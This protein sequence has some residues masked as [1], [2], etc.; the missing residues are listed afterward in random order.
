MFQSLF[1]ELPKKQVPLEGIDP[2]TDIVAGHS[3]ISASPVT[4]R[5]GRLVSD[6]PALAKVSSALYFPPTFFILFTVLDP[7]FRT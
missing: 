6:E 3:V 5:P 7:C 2:A 4:A 1:L